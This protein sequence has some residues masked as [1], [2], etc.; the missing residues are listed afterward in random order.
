MIIYGGFMLTFY[1]INS[2]IVMGR[3]KQQKHNLKKMKIAKSES[4][5]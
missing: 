1:I 5:E 4:T 2:F 3:G